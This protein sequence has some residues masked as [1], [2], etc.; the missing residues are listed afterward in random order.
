MKVDE[1]GNSTVEYEMWLRFFPAVGSIGIV[2]YFL[3][4][5]AYLMQSMAHIM[6][7]YFTRREL[8]SP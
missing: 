8:S 3:I 6:S 5:L 1:S 7:E 2:G 4:S